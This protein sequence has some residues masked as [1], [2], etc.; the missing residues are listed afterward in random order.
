[1]QETRDRNQWLAFIRGDKEAFSNLYLRYHPILLQYGTRLVNDAIEAEETIQELFCYLYEKRSD[2][3]V[4]THVKSYLFLAYRRRLLEKVTSKRNLARIKDA[5]VPIMQL[6]QE[7]IIIAAEYATERKIFLSKVLD[8]LTPNQRE[9]IYLRYY[10]NMSNK[11]IAKMLS[12]KHQSILNILYRSF[13]KLR[14]VL[15]IFSVDN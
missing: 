14:K 10:L 13:K 2:L 11:E 9:V 1:M 6:S 7:D 5:E 4:V 15:G 8:E 12:M 3:A